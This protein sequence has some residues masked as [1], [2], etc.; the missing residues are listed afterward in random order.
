MNGPMVLLMDENTSSDGEIIADMFKRRGLGPIIGRRSWGGVLGM[1]SEQLVDGTSVTIP[2]TSYWIAG[3]GFGIE[4][5]GI[6]PFAPVTY[7]PQAYRA[8]TDP[9]LAAAMA[10]ALADLAAGKDFAVCKQ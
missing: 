9:Q 5:H 10:Q 6:E 4:N 8:G 7:P 3:E 1:N 2:E